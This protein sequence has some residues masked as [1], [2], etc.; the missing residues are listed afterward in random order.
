MKQSRKQEVTSQASCSGRGL[1]PATVDSVS[2]G[3]FTLA[4]ENEEYYNILDDSRQSL[5][6]EHVD[7]S[8][9]RREQ[10]VD[11]LIEACDGLRRLSLGGLSSSGQL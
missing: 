2:F 3:S 5:C 7:E 6:R 1:S 8:S 4:E 11:L 10:A 9:V